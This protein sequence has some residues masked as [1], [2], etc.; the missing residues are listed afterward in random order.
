MT[1]HALEL[2]QV[3]ARLAGYAF[4]GLAADPQGPSLLAVGVALAVA[5][6]ALKRREAASSLE[7]V[8]PSALP[9]TPGGTWESGEPSAALGKV[10]E[11]SRGREAAL[12][13]R[14]PGGGE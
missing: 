3:P 10:V 14:T 2:L 1:E 5:A 7:A 9:S 12:D 6:V 13:V 11:A 4:D 8:V